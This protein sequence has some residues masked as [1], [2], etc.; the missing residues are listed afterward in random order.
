MIVT[1]T[2]TSK[3]Q[4]TL[5]KA[6]REK[7]DVKKGDRIIA[8]TQGKKVYLVPAGRGILDLVGRMP[9]LNVPKGK[10]VDDLIAEARDEYFSK[11]FR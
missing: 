3:G 5:P 9:K 4:V 11:T 2:V 6:I 8:K 7:L 10:T 1:M